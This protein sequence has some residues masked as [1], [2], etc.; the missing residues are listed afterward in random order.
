MKK[1]LILLFTLSLLLFSSLAAYGFNSPTVTEGEWDVMAMFVTEGGLM[2]GGE[3]GINPDLAVIAELGSPYSKIGVI[4]ELKSNLALTGGIAGSGLFGGV[5]GSMP[6]GK[7]L[8]G[9][10]E[11]DLGLFNDLVALMYEIGVRYRIDSQWDLRGG[12]VGS[13]VGGYNGMGVGFGAGYR[14]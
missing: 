12:I 6:M 10:G 5:I 13:F 8:L 11:L 1:L 3:Y 7:N 14:F 9:I 2:V 4:Y